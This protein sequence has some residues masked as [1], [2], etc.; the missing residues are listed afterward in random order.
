MQEDGGDGEILLVAPPA[1][2]LKQYA[3]KLVR[4]E[5]AVGTIG[6]EVVVLMQAGDHV[7]EGLAVCAPVRRNH[8]KQSKEK[9][10]KKQKGMR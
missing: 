9:K 8:R 2:H 10:N 4:I 1:I 7:Q 5:G 6:P 3:G